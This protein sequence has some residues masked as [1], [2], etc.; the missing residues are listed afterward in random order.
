[1]HESCV[2]LVV[3]IIRL[4]FTRAIKQIKSIS[5]KEEAEVHLIITNLR[6]LVQLN[7]QALVFAVS[8]SLQVCKSRLLRSIWDAQCS[9]SWAAFDLDWICHR[10]KLITINIICT[11]SAPMQQ[12]DGHICVSIIAGVQEC[13]L[14]RRICRT[15]CHLVMSRV[16]VVFWLLKAKFYWSTLSVY[17]LL[18][19]P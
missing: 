4:L 3:V 12:C 1:M 15:Q 6:C 18:S 9:W 5:H 14:L 11:L 8:L 19:A 17:V 16:T 10:Y 7:R 13:G 2:T